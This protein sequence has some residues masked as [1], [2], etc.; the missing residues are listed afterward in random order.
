NRESPTLSPEHHI[1]TVL[2][3]PITISTRILSGLRFNEVITDHFANQE[4]TV[5]KI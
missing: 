4:L 2:D 3:L 5:F 1:E